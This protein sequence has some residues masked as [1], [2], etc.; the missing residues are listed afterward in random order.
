[1]HKTFEWKIEQRLKG[2]PKY[3]LNAV[4]DKLQNS[5]KFEVVNTM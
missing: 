5:D 2:W 1:M 4:A 3:N